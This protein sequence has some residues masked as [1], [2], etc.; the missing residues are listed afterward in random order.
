[1]HYNIHSHLLLILAHTFTTNCFVHLWKQKSGS[2]SWLGVNVTSII[3][4]VT[5]DS[6]DQ[7]FLSLHSSILPYFSRWLPVGRSR[8]TV[9]YHMLVKTLSMSVEPRSCVVGYFLFYFSH[10]VLDVRAQQTVPI[11]KKK[12][13]RCQWAVSHILHLA[14]M[15]AINSTW[16][17]VTWGKTRPSHIFSAPMS[18]WLLVS[19]AVTQ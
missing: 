12:Q 17:E 14:E 8:L 5:E 7:M 18:R 19:S 1:M 9:W 10:T 6:E 2:I 15:S 11:L 3:F 13:D 4:P 16:N